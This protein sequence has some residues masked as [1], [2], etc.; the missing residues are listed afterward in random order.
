MLS[1]LRKYRVGLVLSGQ[2]LSGIKSSILDAILG[3]VGS[4]MIFRLGVADASAMARQLGQ[5]EPSDLINLPNYRM[6]CRVMVDGLVSKAFGA[7]TLR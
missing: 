7:R 5:I 6:Y 3:N 1:E 4:L 2:Y